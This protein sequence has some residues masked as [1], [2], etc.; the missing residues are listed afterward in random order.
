MRGTGISAEHFLYNEN[1]LTNCSTQ[2]NSP[3]IPHT[4]PPLLHHHHYITISK[5]RVQSKSSLSRMGA[6]H[7]EGGGED[8]TEAV[9]VDP[10]PSLLLSLFTVCVCVY[11]C[12]EKRV[13]MWVCQH[14]CMFVSKKYCRKSVEILEDY[15][16]GILQAVLKRSQFTFQRHIMGPAGGLME[17]LRNAKAG[18]QCSYEGTTWQMASTVE[19]KPKISISH[20]WHS[21]LQH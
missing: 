5:P 16:L 13:C 1:N 6:R 4:P 9:G 19:A 8:K 15:W 17:L 21:H 11:V 12:K 3:P 7:R 20:G 18:T 2:R 10:R 14:K